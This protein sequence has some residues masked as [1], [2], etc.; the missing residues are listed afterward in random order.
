[1]KKFC[2]IMLTALA[3]A[4][5]T[6][7]GEKEFSGSITEQNIRDDIG[8][9]SFVIEDDTGKQTGVLMTDETSV[10]SLADGVDEEDFLNG[11]LAGAEV[12]VIP[13]KSGRRSIAVESGEEI[14][15]YNADI[16]TVEWA[17]AAENEVLSDGTQVELWKG[18]SSSVYRLPDGTD[19]LTLQNNTDWE[20]M[21]SADD[22]NFI[23]LDDEVR[24]KIRGYYDGKGIPY[25]VTCE[26]ERA[27]EMYLNS[28]NR[29]NFGSCPLGWEIRP[30][31][32]S[33]KV[34]Y[35]RSDVTLPVGE[36]EGTVISEGTAFDRENG[37][38]IDTWDLFSCEEQIVKN[39]LLDMAGE[40][41]PEARREME[42][43]LLP[44][45]ILFEQTGMEVSFPKGTLPDQEHV[46]GIY[47]DYNEKISGILYEWAC[48]VTEESNK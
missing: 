30:T 29:D 37:L 38:K 3:A 16:I 19:L 14:P 17:K 5:F 11:K 43:A 18:L 23:F 25:N 34:I 9:I 35:F 46:Y 28:G 22:G 33:E 40:Q 20:D 1:M 12:T 39:T 2:I 41:P 6:G 24:K 15:A 8:I 26:L 48:P 44:E 13:Q 36:G 4:A 31:A 42:E 21:V 45:Y 27:Y 32:Y 7:C 10:I 47:F